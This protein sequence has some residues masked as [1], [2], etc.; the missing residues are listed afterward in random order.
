MEEIKKEVRYINNVEL[1]ASAEPDSREIQGTAIVFNSPS[2]LLGTQTGK[3]FRETIKS[4]A[5]SDE[6]LR[7]SDIMMLYNHSDSQGILARSKKGKGSL[8]MTKDEKGVHFK[9]MAKRTALGEEVL[10]AVRAGDLS[11][12][13]FAMH[14]IP[15]GKNDTWTRGT[16]GNYNREINSIS[17]LYDLSIVGQPAYESTQVSTRGLDLLV[18][19][20]QKELERLAEEKRVADEKKLADEKLAEEKRI[21]DLKVY[22]VELRKQLNL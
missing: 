8:M 6:L 9:F 15:D 7:N 10:Q 5:I 4:T 11:G 3:Q 22:Y 20:E 19:A 16:D 18:E 1:R 17:A 2:E 12:A 13:S 14:V 21:A